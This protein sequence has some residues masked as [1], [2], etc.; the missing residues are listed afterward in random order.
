MNDE[1]SREHLHDFARAAL[2][3]TA[4][5][6]ALGAGVWASWLEWLH[7]VHFDLQSKLVRDMNDPKCR[8]G[9][10]LEGEFTVE[11]QEKRAG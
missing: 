2:V 6:A 5:V 1:P 7:W 8:M 3:D 4:A 11:S 10:M 9:E